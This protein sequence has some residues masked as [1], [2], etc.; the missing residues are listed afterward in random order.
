MRHSGASSDRG[1]NS[2]SFLKVQRRGQWRS[3]S[4]VQRYEKAARLATSLHR[5]PP[6]LVAHAQRC[7]SRVA[8]II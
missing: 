8:D 6:A 3:V 7:E 5:L 1:D 2:R 4:S